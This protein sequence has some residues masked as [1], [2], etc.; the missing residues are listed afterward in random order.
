MSFTEGAIGSVAPPP[1]SSIPP[2]LAEHPDYEV[3]GELGRGGMGVV[4]LAQNKLMGRKEVLKVVSRDLMTRRGVLDRFLREIRN[5]AQLHHTNIVTAYSAIR[6]GE[7]MVFAMEY[8]EGYDLAQFVKVRGPLPVPLACNFIHQAAV[9]LQ[10]AHEQ[11]MVHRDIKPGNLILARKGNKPVVK[12]LDFGLAKATREGPLDGSLTQEGQMLGTPDYIAPEQSLNATKADIRADVY[13]L[14]CTLYYLLSGGPP[15]SGSSLY[16]VLQAHHSMEARP[17]NLLRPEVP[18]ELAAVVGKLMAKDPARRYQTPAEV[19]QALKPFFKP[20]GPGTAA[21]RLQLSPA[22]RPAAGHVVTRQRP[23]PAIDRATPVKSTRRPP[24][25]KPLEATEADAGWQDLL[26]TADGEREPTAAAP[27]EPVA[28][29]ANLAHWPWFWPAAAAGL[30]LLGLLIGWVVGNRKVKTK[31]GVIVPEKV[32]DHAIVPPVTPAP[33]PALS[34]APAHDHQQLTSWTSRAK[35]NRDLNR[36]DDRHDGLGFRVVVDAEGGLA[37]RLDSARAGS[38]KEAESPPTPSSGS[39][40]PVSSEA[41][42]LGSAVRRSADWTSPSTGMTFLRIPGGEFMMGSPEEDEDAS[43]DEKPAHKVR[44]SPF[45]LGVTEVTQ[46]QY[47]DVTGHN[48]SWFSTAGRGKEAVAGEVTDRYPV[49]NISWLDAI[50]YSNAL[51]K[52]DGLAP[53]YVIGDRDVEAASTYASGYRLP[54]EAE[55]E[56]ACRAATSTKYS[57]GSDPSQLRKYAWYSANSGGISHG[58][59]QK[60]P[61]AFGLYDMHGNVWEW[62]WDCYGASYDE[63][64][65]ADSPLGVPEASGRVDRGGGWDNYPRYCRSANRRGGPPANRNYA[66]GFRLARSQSGR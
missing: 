19:A 52:K 24:T 34:T 1:A 57:F 66:L 26:E 12:V 6:A 23:E 49:E 51:S 65:R 14:G 53:Y 8:V 10:Y 64:S 41:G 35:A 4:Y 37:G 7:S 42:Q 63:R 17:L 58:V 38:P 27:Q 18:W 9:G 20:V 54:T 61:N 15:F 28:L 48:P 2:G 50:R 32:A 40:A 56:F 33:R 60:H 47:K 21:S 36:P 39:K 44:V 13:S 46:A 31:D 59:G 3:L 25:K 22:I 43:D 30:L 29:A 62:C 11:G 55:W 16:E 5:A 45:L